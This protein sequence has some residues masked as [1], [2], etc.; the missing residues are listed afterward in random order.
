[1]RHIRARYPCSPAWVFTHTRAPVPTLIPSF[2]A[3]SSSGLLFRESSS[4]LNATTTAPIVTA[5]LHAIRRL[6]GIS[7]GQE[8][9]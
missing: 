3:L 9:V 6:V 1:M 2:P 5:A 8:K 4:T 7:G